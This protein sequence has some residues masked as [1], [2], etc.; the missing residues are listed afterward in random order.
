MLSQLDRR[1]Q[2]TNKVSPEN[3]HEEQKEESKE[4]L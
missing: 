3:G 4:P 2:P 1:E